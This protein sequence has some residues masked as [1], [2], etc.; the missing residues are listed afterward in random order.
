MDM[1]VLLLH[2]SEADNV[3]LEAMGEP[4]GEQLMLIRSEHHS[5]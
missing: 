5:G 2:Q 4:W 1:L 3:A